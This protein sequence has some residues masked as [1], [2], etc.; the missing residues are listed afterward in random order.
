MKR[1]SISALCA[2]CIAAAFAELKEEKGIVY[3]KAV[4]ECHLNVR[5]PVGAK[6]LPVLV[7]FHGGGLQGGKP[8]YCYYPKGDESVVNVAVK[9]RLMPKCGFAQC[10]DDAAASVAWVL[11]NIEKYGGDPAKVFVSGHSAGGYLTAMVGLDEKWLAKYKHHPRELRGLAPISGQVTE[12][13]NVRQKNGDVDPQYAPKINERAPLYYLR[14]KRN[15]FLPFCDICGDRKIEWPCRVEENEFMCASMKKLGWGGVEFHECEGKTHGSVSQSAPAI[16]KKF[17]EKY[18]GNMA[19]VP[20]ERLQIDNYDWYKRHER[21]LKEQSSMNPDIVFVGDSITHF[22]AGRDT[23]GGNDALPRWKKAFGDYKT[24]N[25][26]FGWDR[27]GNVLWRLENGEMDGTDPK[28]VVVHIG[29]NNFT[30]TAMYRGDSGEEVA[31]GV[32]AVVKAV[33]AKAPKAHIVAMG[34]FPF[35][36]YPNA[37][38]RVKAGTA[39]RI[40]EKEL[41]LLDSNLTFMDITS[42]QISKNGEYDPKLTRGD[43]VHPS[44]EGYDI[45]ANEILPVVKKYAK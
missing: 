20:Q 28:V 36:R 5:Y 8:T 44:D 42:K 27:T 23:I 31:E 2:F 37:P 24:L 14:N 17:V 21:I 10:I 41:P 35:G 16:L 38:H 3:N 29:G 22:W 25:I 40:L 9:Y 45:W 19:L 30:G 34:V 39:N 11:E 32:K 12:H 4:P 1:L 15:F 33:R 43:F 7:F 6:G 26:G 13:F 18:G